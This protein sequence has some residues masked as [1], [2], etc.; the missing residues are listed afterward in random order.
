MTPVYFTTGA[1]QTE[2][3]QATTGNLLNLYA[4]ALPAGAKV[5]AA[6]LSTPGSKLT[7]TLPEDS[8][9]EAMIIIDRVLYVVGRQ[10]FTIIPLDTPETRTEYDNNVSGRVSLATN[11]NDIMWVDGVEAWAYT[12]DT[13]TFKVMT[14]EPNVYPSNTITF[15]DGYFLLDRKG[16]NQFYHSKLFSLEF[17][18]LDF[19]SAESSFDDVQAVVALRQEL[20][21]FGDRSIEVW[22]NSGGADSTFLPIPGAV[23]ERGTLSPYSMTTEDNS[24]YWLG[25]DGVVYRAAQYQPVRISTHALES[26]LQDNDAVGAF[27]FSYTYNG[28]S[29]YVLTMPEVPMTWVYDAASGEWHKWETFG[30]NR[31]WA[32][33]HIGRQHPDGTRKHYIGDFQSGNIYELRDD[34]HDD[35][36]LPL[37]REGTSQPITTG[38]RDYF[39]MRS[40]EVDINSGVGIPHGLGSDPV[41]QMEWSDDGGVSYCDAKFHKMG[42]IGERFARVKR[43]NM[44]RSRQRVMRLRCSDPVP[45][46]I[47]GTYAEIEHGSR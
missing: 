40:F 12:I 14:A 1:A 17:D 37:V 25:D 45:V 19:N 33:C 30:F 35:N 4:E 44:G 28:H 27:A 13:E 5:P 2:A 46:K 3:D 10:K 26:A 22:Y 24:I 18:A 6:L 23:L 20:W 8:S 47:M 39:R 38:G 34:Q 36:G 43:W 29:F 7:F 32:N 15:L 16:T 21:V 41:M 11:G 42:K 9:I 31:H